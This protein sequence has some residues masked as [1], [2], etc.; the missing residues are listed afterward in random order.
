MEANR[1]IVLSIAGLDPSAGA[2]LLA[3]IKTFEE[4]KVYG[5]GISTAQTLQTENEFFTIRWEEEK[6]ILQSLETMLLQYNV[7]VVKIGIV[8]NIGVLNRIVSFIH[9]IDNSLKIVIDTV[10]KSSSGFNF[11]NKTINEQVLFETFSKVFLITPNYNEAIQLWPSS[12]AKEAAGWMS[13]L[14]TA[15]A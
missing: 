11:W 13:R 15:D 8:E 10:I 14:S 12:N 5:L 2:G 1:P 3:D 4:Y 9:K 7:S 6:D